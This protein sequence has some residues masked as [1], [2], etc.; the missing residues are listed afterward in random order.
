MCM[1]NEKTQTWDDILKEL[2]KVAGEERVITDPAV[3]EG[4]SK[5]KSFVSPK[6][7]DCVVRVR[8]MLKYRAW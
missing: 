1:A 5:D 2:K 8:I 3:L 7:P 6:M 4:Y